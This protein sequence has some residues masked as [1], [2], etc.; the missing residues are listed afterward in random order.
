M[1][2]LANESRWESLQD[3][4]WS[5]PPSL[6]EIVLDINL[7]ATWLNHAIDLMAFGSEAIPSDLLERAARRCRASRALC[8]A[9]RMSRVAF[10]GNPNRPGDGSDLIPRGYF[11]QP[12]QLG[13][14]DNSLE[15]AVDLISDDEFTV[16]YEGRHQ[17]WFNVRVQTDT[18]MEWLKMAA[19]VQLEKPRRG[20]PAEYNWT[21]VKSRLLQYRSQHGPVRTF[22]ELLQKC[23]DFASELHPKRR[24]PDDNTIREAIRKHELDVAAGS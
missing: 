5:P 7:P 18:L 9:A 16:A 12:R 3:S 19:A 15:T 17:K 14:A 10:I 24:T 2:K 13:S 20:R 4:P 23:S 1:I 11:D 6:N 22:D 8:Q 21:G